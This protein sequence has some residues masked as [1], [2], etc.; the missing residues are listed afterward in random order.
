VQTQQNTPFGAFANVNT[1]PQCRGTGEIIETPCKECNGSGRI[2]TETTIPVEIPAGI[3]DNMAITMQGEGEPG[4]NGGPPGDL[5]VMIRVEGHKMFVRKGNDLYLDIPITFDQAAL[6]TTITV[7]TL[8]E[9]VQYKVPPGTQP[10]TVFRL[11]GKGV[12]HL[13]GNKYGHLYV[14]VNLEVPTKLNANQKK[15]LKDM[16]KKIGPEAYSRRKTFADA[17]KELFS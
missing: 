15:A 5:Y 2:R 8:D 3:D 16:A 14:K 10:D 1:C 17:V 13:R 11:K 4:F 6:G 7:P 9:K 12:K